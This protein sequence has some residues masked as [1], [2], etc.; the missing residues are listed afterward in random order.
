MA[1]VV[2][3]WLSLFGSLLLLALLPLLFAELM[4]QSLAKLHLSATSALLL[5]IAVVLGSFV[6][7]PIK[8][9]PHAETRAVHPLAVFGLNNL[10]PELRRVRAETVVAVNVG[11]CVIPVALAVYETAYVL[12][13]DPRHLA[14]VGV[15]CLIN[16]AV[17]HFLARPVAGVGIALPSLVPALV[18]ASLALLLAPEEAPPVAFIAGIAGPLVGADLLHLRDLEKIASGVVSIGGAGTFD[19]IVLSGIIA[20]YLA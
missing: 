13:R 19:G 9:I 20:V 14:A 7:I 4:A 11:G 12:A 18:A 6:N 8:R 15:A 3:I 16:I 17:C 1:M 2:L 10:W 5:V